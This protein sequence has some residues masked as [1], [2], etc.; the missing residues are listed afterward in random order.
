[1]DLMKIT[2]ISAAGMQ[3][4]SERLRVVA[5]NLANAYSTGTTPGSEPYRRRTISFA[6]GLNKELGLPTVRV[7]RYG[8]DQS[9]FDREY[10]PGHPAADENGYVLRPNVNP[11]VEM[12]DM[13]EAQRGYEANLSV[14][15]TTRTM[16]Q[17]A[18]DLLR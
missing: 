2:R 13:R 9:P 11:V 3:V 14:I 12:V 1:M 18:L 5:E 16:V 10:D 4:Q 6:E 7:S 17:R 15:E 8:V